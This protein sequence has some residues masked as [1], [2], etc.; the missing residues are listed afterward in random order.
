MKR[1]RA[2]ATAEV[3]AASTLLLDSEPSTAGLIAPGAAPLCEVL[4]SD[5]ARG[6]FLR[7]SARN[8]WM[9]PLWRCLERFTLPGITRHYWLRK[10]WI[11]ARVRTQIAG[12]VRRVVVLG[13]GLDTLAL[14]LAP[15]WPDVDW[16]EVDHPAT[17]AMKQRALDRAGIKVPPTLR[18]AAADLAINDAWPDSVGTGPQATVVVIEGLLMYLARE[19]VEEVLARQLPA[20]AGGSLNI[21]F[22]YMVQWPQGRGG[23]R[24]SS[25]LIDAWLAA[26]RE[27]FLWMHEPESLP[28]WLASLGYSVVAH[29]EPPF[30]AWDTE[31]PHQVGLLRGENLVEAQLAAPTSPK[32]A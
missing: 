8:K 16:I 12:G 14:R 1:D 13:A 21:V 7:W 11:E 10:Q 9:R 6:R 25:R 4:L 24:P 30:G 23:F 5:G 28:Q 2:S 18:F 22:S 32:A 27:P 15:L 3:I 19:K 17:Q 29:A 31:R 20:L 26:Q